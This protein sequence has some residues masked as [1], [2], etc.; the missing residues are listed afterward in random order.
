MAVYTTIDDPSA[1]F[2]VQLYT[3][4]GSE[5]VITFDD[6]DT[7]MTP[8]MVWTKSRSNALNH[9]L[10]D[11]VRGAT[12]LLKPNLSNTEGTDAQS[13][14]SFNSDGFTIGTDSHINTSSA[15]F[16]SWNWKANGSGS[17]NEDGTINTTA[18]S[19]NIRCVITK[20]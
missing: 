4:N 11:V 20:C 18:T 19:A 17:S 8:D 1:Y 6:T 13:L 2:K 15:T 14:K 16:V 3:G 7:T 10:Y 12:N 5:N 9:N